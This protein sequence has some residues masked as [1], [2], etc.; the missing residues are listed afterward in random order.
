MEEEVKTLQKHI[1]SIVKI[2][3]DL[4]RKDNKLSPNE[5][6]EINET[7]ETQKVITKVTVANYDTIKELIRK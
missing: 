1:G 6:V 2:I 4:K 3:K 5:N 7:L